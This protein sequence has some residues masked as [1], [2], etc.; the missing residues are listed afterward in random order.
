MLPFFNWPLRPTL[1]NF[2]VTPTHSLYRTAA[3][4]D[5]SRAY[6][7]VTKMIQLLYTVA[8]AEMALI[9]TLLF[10]TPLRKL[11]IMSLDKLKRG[12]GPVMVKTVSGTV[13]AV[14]LSSVYSIVK[15]QNSTIEAGAVNPTDQVLMSKHLLEASLMGIFFYWFNFYLMGKIILKS[16][17]TREIH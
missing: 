11:V 12:R 14:L 3:N 5:R 16:T 7:I 10:K 2:S 15:I 6:N 4:V 13:F 17:S 8:F 1:F 9:L